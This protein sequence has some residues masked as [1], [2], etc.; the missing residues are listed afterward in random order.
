M[1]VVNNRNYKKTLRFVWLF[2]VLL[3]IIHYCFFSEKYT[4]EAL[5]SFFES[6]STAIFII[7][8]VL[9]LVR[10]IFFLPSTVFVIMGVALYPNEPFTVLLISMLGILVGSTG[11]YFAAKFLKVE[12]L[13]SFKNQKKI[14]WVESGMEKYGF[15][16]VMAWSFFPPVPT[17]L[18]CYVAGYTKM[19]YL[20]FIV[21]LFVGELIL[22]SIYV[23]TGKSIIQF[24][25]S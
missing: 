21:A 24:V 4:A 20:K 8:V 13:F 9:S 11:I 22:V 23:W 18:I 10:A 3:A 15:S 19:S 14:K 16:V 5:K 6:N 1:S 2:I 12:E 7:Y 17:D 25:F